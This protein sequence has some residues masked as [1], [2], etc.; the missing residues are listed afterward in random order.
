M[1]SSEHRAVRDSVP[2]PN[3]HG[4]TIHFTANIT[5][6][7]NEYSYSQVTTFFLTY[8]KRIA[9]YRLILHEHDT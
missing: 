6:M 8:Q 3:S 4:R 7:S 9:G 1:M 2:Y 5:Q